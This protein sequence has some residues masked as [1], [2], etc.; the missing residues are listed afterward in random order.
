MDKTA[1]ESLLKKQSQLQA[2]IQTLQ[3]KAETQK[4]KED[5]RRKILAG[6]YILFKVERAGTEEAFISEL[7]EFLFRKRDRELFG[8]P[9]REEENQLKK[10][11]SES[12]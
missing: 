12:V 5:T 6:A 4:R 8:L 9:P 11:T 7:D 1:L 10:V 2:R 3:A